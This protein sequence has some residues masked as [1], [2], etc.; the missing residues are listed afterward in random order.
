MGLLA[1]LNALD[2]SPTPTPVTIDPP[3]HDVTRTVTWSA[4][5]LPLLEAVK[6]RW[7]Q[8]DEGAH[9]LGFYLLSFLTALS[10]H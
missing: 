7:V 9:R 1:F 6:T 2:P 10:G 3:G 8:D 4:T 5:D